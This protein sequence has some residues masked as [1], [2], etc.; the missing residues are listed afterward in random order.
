MM[1]HIGLIALALAADPWKVISMTPF[2]FR[3][4]LM[5]TLVER[6]S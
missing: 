1:I 2:P 3:D 6:D 4:R 5:C